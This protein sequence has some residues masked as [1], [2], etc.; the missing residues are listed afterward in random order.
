MR[1]SMRY[2]SPVRNRFLAEPQCNVPLRLTTVPFE[3]RRDG[4]PSERSPIHTEDMPCGVRP[5][6]DCTG[7]QTTRE[8]DDGSLV[9]GHLRASRRNS[10]AG[11]A[12]NNR[13]TAHPDQRT[14]NARPITSFHE[15]HTPTSTQGAPDSS[16]SEVSARQDRQPKS[17]PFILL[18]LQVVR[19][20]I[21]GSYGGEQERMKRHTKP[22]WPIPLFSRNG[23]AD[24]TA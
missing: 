21:S 15:T 10:L 16:G 17:R 11:T 19:G 8:F 1:S 14:S 20:E 22:F 4:S 18:L 2:H 13:E 5:S 9:I 3:L 12:I 6:V 7:R 23:Q 24:G